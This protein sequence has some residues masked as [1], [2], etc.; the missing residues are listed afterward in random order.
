MTEAEL[1]AW[2]VECALMG[3]YHLTA[4]GGGS[5]WE[6]RTTLCGLPVAGSLSTLFA[7]TETELL[8][9]LEAWSSV[10]TSICPRCVVTDYGMRHVARSGPTSERYLWV[11]PNEVLAL[12]F[13][14]E[15]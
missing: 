10:S 7:M 1:K 6:L 4:E 8:V 3:Y 14:S 2:E 13:C 9:R 15:V 5:H 12:P 11:R